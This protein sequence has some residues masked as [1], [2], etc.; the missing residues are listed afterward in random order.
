MF[1]NFFNHFRITSSSFNN[2][3][4]EN[5]LRKLNLLKN[6]LSLLKRKK[7]SKQN[8]QYKQN[9]S[10]T[11]L[12]KYFPF[13]ICTGLMLLNSKINYEKKFNANEIFRAFKLESPLMYC[14]KVN[15]KELEKMMGLLETQIKNLEFRYQG[16]LRRQPVK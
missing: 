16:K 6:K 13:A 2:T 9:N 5:L 4:L 14:Y 10:N 3:P 12:T 15:N 1:K 7:G 11:E 8:K